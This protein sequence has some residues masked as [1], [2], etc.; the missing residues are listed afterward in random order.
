[1][2]RYKISFFIVVILITGCSKNFLEEKPN[3]SI[4]VPVSL[5]DY[6]S[7][8]D[9]SNILNQTGSLPQLSSD[10][11]FIIDKPTFDGLSSQ[12]Q[13]NAYLW[14]KNLYGGVVG[15]L[16]WNQL[17]KAVFYANSVL[18]GLTKL[19]R[20]EANKV[21]WDNIKGEAL[22]FRSF[23][24]SDLARN[25]CPVYNETSGDGDLG[26]PLK[27]SANIDEIVPRSSLKETYNKIIVDLNEALPLLNENIPTFNRNRPSKVAVNALLARIYL[28]MGKYDKASIAAD[29]VLASYNS[30]IDYNTINASSQTPFSYSALETIFSSVQIYDYSTTTGYNS[31]VEIGV[32]PTLIQTYDAND[33]RLPIFYVKNSINNYNVKR[34]Y[35]GGGNY[36]FTGLAVDEI[37][38]IKAECAAR[39]NNS[40]TAIDILNK[41]LVNRYKT[42]SYV[43][44][45]S[46]S[47]NDALSLVLLERRKELV[48][49]S[50]R[51]FDLKRLNREGAN[52]LLKR[53]LNG[54]EYKLLPNSLLYV[55]PI[56]DDEIALSGIQQNN[57]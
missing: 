5:S 40:K 34:G 17:Y 37:L 33:L 26:I 47:A 41:L 53:V 23:A 11:Y 57:R 7:L 15:I 9:N 52:I 2:K 31:R 25:F 24:F 21:E 29:A 44:V 28:Y 36:A 32:D 27:T 30:L 42:G 3:S 1:M 13:R 19:V 4:L 6:Q 54:I 49:R 20:T 46:V 50:L 56:P 12:V 22:F 43:P 16:D 51:W 39:N 8:L 45:G 10:E 35:V 14:Q 48:W 18:D 38:L 55:F